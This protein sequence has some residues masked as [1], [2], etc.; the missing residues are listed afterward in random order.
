MLLKQV[1]DGP[2]TREDLR[3]G[4]TLSGMK[5]SFLIR[6]AIGGIYKEIMNKHFFS[7]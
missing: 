5:K 6:E 7:Q 2:G 1:T 3:V 4:I